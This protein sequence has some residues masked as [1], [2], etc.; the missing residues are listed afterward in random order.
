MGL[1]LAERP[2]ARC[3]VN[4]CAVAAPCIDMGHPFCTLFAIGPL[5]SIR[6]EIGIQ[7]TGLSYKLK[8]S[9]RRFFHVEARFTKQA[10][11]LPHIFTQ[12]CL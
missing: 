3:P 5:V 7:N 4:L 10:D 2:D 12:H 1:T 9:G 8:L 6:I 11:Q